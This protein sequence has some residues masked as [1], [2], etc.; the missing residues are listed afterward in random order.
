MAGPRGPAGFCGREH[1]INIMN[2]LTLMAAAGFLATA[3]TITLL[4]S[5]RPLPIVTALDTY[6]DGIAEARAPLEGE[7]TLSFKKYQQCR[8]YIGEN[9]QR[10]KT[11]RQIALECHC[12]AGDLCRAFY[13]Y[14]HENPF[15]YSLRLKMKHASELR[16]QKYESAV[17]E[18]HAP[19]S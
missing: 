5:L 1:G 11:L 2:K 13:Q 15:E 10:I 8:Q 12:D 7:G 3:L 4:P 18:I 19:R 17:S 9:F 14:G 6:H 16:R